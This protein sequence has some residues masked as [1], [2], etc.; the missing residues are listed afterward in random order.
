[1]ENI[2]SLRESLKQICQNF[3]LSENVKVIERTPYIPYIPENWNGVLVVAEAQ[4]ITED[5]YRDCSEEQK[6]CRLYPNRD[7][8]QNYEISGSFPKLDVKPWN[9]GS[10]PLAL[11]ASLELNLFETA[12]GNSCFWSIRNGEANENPNEDMRNQSRILWQQMWDVLKERCSKVICCGN[13]ATEIF[14]FIEDDNLTIKE[15]RHP[16]PNA[17]SRVSGMFNKDDLFSRYPEVKNAYDELGFGNPTNESIRN[18]M[19]NKIFFACHAVSLLKT[20]P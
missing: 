3:A 17:M 15:L 18:Y 14:N 20:E 6:I 1:M 7:C 12:V 11:K 5:D 10:I 19:Q 2:L 8:L 9:D 4:N 16:S 13:I